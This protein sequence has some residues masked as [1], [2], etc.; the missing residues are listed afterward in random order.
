MNKMENKDYRKGK[1]NL[2]FYRFKLIGYFNEKPVF[3]LNKIER[4]VKIK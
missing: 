1:I 2:I 3:K 4:K